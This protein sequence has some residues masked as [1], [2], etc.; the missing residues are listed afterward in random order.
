MFRLTR[1]YSVASFLGIA[2]SYFLDYPTGASVVCA[3][4][5]VLGFIALVRMLK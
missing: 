3:F 5:A 1:T 4:G 2:I